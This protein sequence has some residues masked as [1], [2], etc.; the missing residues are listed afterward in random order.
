[1]TDEKGHWIT[2]TGCIDRD[3]RTVIYGAGKYGRELYSFLK[4]KGLPRENISFAVTDKRGNPEAIDGVPVREARELREELAGCQIFLAI[5]KTHAGEAEDLLRACGAGQWH[6]VTAEDID[7]ISEEIFKEMEPLAL[8][9]N[10]IFFSCYEGMG[11]RCSCKYIAQRLI[12]DQAPVTMVWV[13]TDGNGRDVPEPIKKVELYSKAYYRELYTSK[14][15]ITNNTNKLFGRK[16][17]GQYHINT[18]HGF[19]PFKKV[20]GSVPANRERR[21][22]IRRIN[23]TYDLFLSGSAF[24][25][26]V[27]RDSFFY[28]GEIRQWGAPRNDA[29]FA[30]GSIKDM[31]YERFG[32]PPHK[33]IVL[34]APT[35]RTDVEHSFAQYDLDM[36]KVLEALHDRFGGEYV[37]MY[38]FHHH[39]YELGE[40]REFYRDGIDATHYS[41]VQELLAAADVVITDYSS[42]MWDFSLQRRPVFLYQNDERTFADDRGFYCPVSQWPYPRAR[43]GE[44][45]AARIRDFD[46]EAYIRELDAFLERYGACDDGKASLRAAKRIMEVI[47]RG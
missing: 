6:R 45:M 38:R 8:E 14:I 10:K 41:D 36:E 24:Y 40:C 27:Y 9:K 22:E 34:Y 15:C 43:S 37:L 21:E 31:V 25:A 1:M 28:E 5:G 26:Q 39:L 11:Y 23:K 12:Q 2:D 42:L 47:E 29:L 16:K 33:K 19:G 7:L 3:A 18:W 13:V 32:I 46:Q 20:Q 44:E 17:E 4:M 30:G 35:F